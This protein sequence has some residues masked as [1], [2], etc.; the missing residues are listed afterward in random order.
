MPAM[1]EIWPAFFRLSAPFANHGP[2]R[3]LALVFIILYVALE[4]NGPG[5]TDPIG[6]QRPRQGRRNGLDLTLDQQFFVSLLQIIWIDILLSGDNAVVIALACRSLPDRQRKWGIICG[7][8]AA[9]ILRILFAVFVVFLLSVPYLKIVGSLL[10]FWIAVKLVLPEEGGNGETVK[11]GNSLFS[12][13][14]TIVIADAVM[15]L[16]NVIAI[17]AASHGRVELLVLGLLISIP[18]IVYGSTLVLKALERFRSLITAGGALLGWIAADVLVTDPVL[19]GWIE[20]E[21]RYLHDWYIAP[22]AG[23][24]FV[25]VVGLSL[26]RA[27]ETRRRQKLDL[28]S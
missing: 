8:G 15:S 12:A 7:A 28:V 17:A 9:I 5:S 18:L 16:D 1:T 14:R 22:I 20:R 2:L 27:I 19:V 21:A 25:V 6:V 3:A 26:A 11:G 23:A 4:D 10:L 13:V 24:L